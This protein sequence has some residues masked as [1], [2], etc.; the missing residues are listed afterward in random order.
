M[1]ASCQDTIEAPIRSTCSRRPPAREPPRPGPFSSSTGSS[2]RIK[3]ERPITLD[4]GYRRPAVANSLGQSQRDGRTAECRDWKCRVPRLDWNVANERATLP[5]DS[6]TREACVTCGL[7]H[8]A[9]ST[10]YDNHPSAPESPLRTQPGCLPSGS[11]ALAAACPTPSDFGGGKRT[12]PRA[13]ALA[14]PPV[15]TPSRRVVPR[16]DVTLGGRQCL[17]RKSKTG[18]TV[19]TKGWGGSGSNRRRPDYEIEFPLVTHQEVVAI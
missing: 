5:L 15:A 10:D 19:G 6:A 14:L 9:I 12:S 2:A 16:G 17:G 4:G 11:A 1:A 7:R 8:P 18:K 13:P 3:W